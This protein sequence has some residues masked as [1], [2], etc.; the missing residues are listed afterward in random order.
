[1]D[2]DDIAQPNGRNQSELTADDANVA[3]FFLIQS[4]LSAIRAISEI[5]G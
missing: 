1:M 2:A 3:D 4:A 5:R